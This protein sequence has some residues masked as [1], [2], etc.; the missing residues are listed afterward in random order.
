[1]VGWL[2]KLQGTTVKV[3]KLLRLPGNV[4]R[5]SFEKTIE[6]ALLAEPWPL[7]HVL[8]VLGAV[9]RCLPQLMHGY[10]PAVIPALPRPGQGWQG[11]ADLLVVLPALSK[12]MAEPC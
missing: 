5:S 10:T 12:D 8:A 11:S 6:T 1:M 7:G 2:G 9:V 3:W 4:P